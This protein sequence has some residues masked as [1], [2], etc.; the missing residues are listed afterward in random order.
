M[1]HSFRFFLI[2]DPTGGWI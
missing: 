2:W 1:K